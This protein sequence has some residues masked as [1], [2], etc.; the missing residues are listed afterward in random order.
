MWCNVGGEICF[1]VGEGVGMVIMLGL[2]V[3]VGELVINLVLCVMMWVVVVE[4]LV[5]LLFGV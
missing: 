1:F 2:W 5:E 3:V 4:V